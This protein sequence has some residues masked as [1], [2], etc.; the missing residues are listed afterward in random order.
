MNVADA[1]TYHAVHDPTRPAIFSP[2]A[3]H[4]L[5]FRELRAQFEALATA[6]TERLEL[7]A[8]DRVAVLSR[9]TAEYFV[10]YLACAR[11]GLV[12][13]GVNWRFA[14]PAIEDALR[15]TQP[16]VV[17][18]EGHFADVVRVLRDS[19]ALDHVRWYGFGPDSD[20]K[21]EGLIEEGSGLKPT[22]A[23]IDGDAPY[24]LISTGGTTGT[25]KA[26]L[27]SHD[28]VNAAMA[29]NSIAERIAPSDRYMLIGQAFHSAAVLALN[30]LR[31]GCAIVV[32]NFDAFRA[33]E[34]IKHYKVTAFLGFP[35]ML[36]YMLEHAT[37]AAEDLQS[38]RNVQYGGGA[39]SESTILALMDS[40]PCS[41]IQCY[42]TTE[43]IGIT[44]LG[45]E[46]HERARRGETN[47]LR[48]CGLPATLT[49]VRIAAFQ[50]KVS[51]GGNP[52]GEV[53][54]RS[55]SNMVGYW[56]DRPPRA[57]DRTM[58]LPTGDIGYVKENLLHILGRS[59]DVI[60]SG[61][62]NIYAS[63]VEN[64]IFS[65]PDVIEAAVV[66]VPDEEWGESVK[67]VVALRS[68]SRASADDIQTWVGERLASYQK[69]RIVEFVRELPKTPTGKVLKRD[70]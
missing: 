5:T 45:Q 48:S 27:H 38:L 28:T 42:G 56:T 3:G 8:G 23:S 43:S 26:A 24:L 25:A 51:D 16:K 36:T 7:R 30:Y 29:N 6:L 67:A 13:Q 52:V 50:G 14:P 21:L 22:R 11:A 59:K 47:L 64:A 17:I 49:D 4:S 35:T 32:L 63:Q 34:A 41:F 39:F 60:I 19:R 31:L 15:A 9:N 10:V 55:P 62:E 1:V 68:G 20:M 37:N 18:F 44:F 57:G 65:H 70:L 58:W 33:V 2:D 61:G 66:G 53:L 69:P 12:A 40:F 54:V 46:E